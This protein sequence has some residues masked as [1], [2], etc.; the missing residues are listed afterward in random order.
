[1]PWAKG[2]FPF[3]IPRLTMPTPRA[4]LAQLLLIC[5]TV[6]VIAAEKN[7]VETGVAI[8]VDASAG[9]RGGLKRGEALHGLALVHSQQ[10]SRTPNSEADPF[11][12]YIS[13]MAIE[14]RGPTEKYLGDFHAASNAEGYQSVRLYSWW[15]EREFG[16]WSLRAGALLADE[17]F[18][19]TESGGY[20][21]NSSF[22][23]PAF[24]S[25]NVKNTGP[26]FFVPALGVRLRHTF[27]TSLSAQLGIYDG[28]S[29]DDP[30][31]DG[32]RTRHGTHYR[33]NSEQGAFV[34][35]ECSLL[36]SPSTEIHWSIKLGG[37]LHTAAFADT[38][39][40]AN[41]DSYVLSGEDPLLHDQNAGAYIVLE[42]GEPAPDGLPGKWLSHVR[43]GFAPADR[44]TLCMSCDVGLAWTGV[45][46]P[47]PDDTLALGFTHSRFSADL[48]DSARDADASSPAPDFEQ[49]L[50][51]SYSAQINERLTVQPDLQYIRHPGGSSALKDAL[52]VML[53]VSASY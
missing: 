3:V 32:R 12:T 35:G 42:R 18:A 9:L 45:C 24:V 16:P 29:F 38:Y 23:W 19:G 33:L 53:R 28:D 2:G 14:G 17:E 22:G 11:T 49:V 5:G 44:N 46:A 20:L 10:T 7:A 37:W 13:L 40:D 26:A 47:R 21:I 31:G 41:G 30:S 1:M 43:A 25:A 52:V 39:A 27:S 34:F 4:S 36:Q 15:L 48:A 6:P 50:E 8:T 51:L